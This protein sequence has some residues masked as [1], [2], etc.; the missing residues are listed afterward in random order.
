MSVTAS[1]SAKTIL[2]GEHAVVYNEPAIAI[3]LSNT[4][5]YAELIPNSNGFRIISPSIHLNKTFDEL[6]P[7]SGLQ[8][9]LIKIK[10]LFDLDNLP[11]LTL[12]IH[13][14]IPIASGLGSGAALSAAVIRAF[15]MYYSQTLSREKINETAYEVEKIYH[16][17]PSG[18][19]NTTI[20]YEQPIIFSK[21]TG[22]CP[23]EADL[24]QFSLLIVDS[25]IRSKTIE[26]VTA[27]R[28]N[29]SHNEPYIR[30]IGKLVQNSVP[31]LQEGNREEIGRLMNENQKLLQM[32][33]VSS[34]KL[35]D[36]IRMGLSHGAIGGKLTGAGRGGNI[37]ILARDE[38]QSKQLRSLY[39]NS[40]FR[41][42]Q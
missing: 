12:L 29:I 33:D 5:T 8:V 26:V 36:L 2:F 25:G 10:E 16:G 21:S 30:E 22:F 41:V 20:A 34:P 24:R 28:E 4:R 6:I 38:E 42:I 32:I 13:S 35:D 15:A 3:P 7:G 18:I 27:V 17:T 14:D 31:F 1:A 37:L 19:D 9:L 23:L 11:D 40:G 39:E